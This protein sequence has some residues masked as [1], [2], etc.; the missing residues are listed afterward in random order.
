[1]AGEMNPDWSAKAEANSKVVEMM[2]KE[3]PKPSRSIAALIV[4]TGLRIEE[5]LA[6]RWCD[7]DLIARTLRVRQKRSTKGSSIS[8][9]RS[10][11]VGSCLYLRL[12]FRSSVCRSR[13]A[14]LPSSSLLRWD[15]A[16]SPQ[17]AQSAV[18][19]DCRKAG[20]EGL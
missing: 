9:R 10:G 16:L 13:E 17:S 5:M 7:V 8:P 20:V 3:L 2:L 11:A 12:R 19:T 4:L 1:M 6:L 18:P 15:P 14:G